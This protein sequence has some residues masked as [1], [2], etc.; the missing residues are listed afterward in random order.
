M[1]LGVDGAMLA[2]IISII[3]VVVAGLSTAYAR[4]ALKEAKKANEINR[5]KALLDLKVVT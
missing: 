2:E 1:F 3:A 5:F 4:R